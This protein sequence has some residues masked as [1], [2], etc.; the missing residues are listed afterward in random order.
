MKQLSFQTLQELEYPGYLNT[1]APERILQFGEGNFLRAFA[2][3]FI[4]L[5]NE[6]TDFNG[7]VVAVQPRSQNPDKADQI[8][9]QDGLYTIYERGYEHR[10]TVNRRKIISSLSRCLN[11]YRDGEELRKLA[12]SPDIR[13]VISNTTEA[14][15]RYDASASLEDE[16]PASFPAKITK[17]LYLRFLARQRML[18]EGQTDLLAGWVFL[19]CELID[20]NGPTLKSY[21]LQHAR[22]WNLGEDFIQWV[23]TENTFCSTM[24][25]R[26]VTGY[27]QGEARKLNHENGYTDEL[28]DTCEAFALWVIQGPEWLKDE[29]PFPRAHVP[30]IFTDDLLP[31]KL[32]KVRILNGSHTAMVPAAY[33][34][35]LNIVRDSMKNKLIRAFFD[36]A[37]QQEIIPTIPLPRYSCLSYMESVAERFVNPYIDHQLLSITLNT[38]SKWRARI[39]PTVLDY[40]KE[41]GRLPECLT[42]SFAFYLAFYR[43]R[44]KKDG[45]YYGRRGEGNFY[46]LKDDPEILEFFYAYRE[47]SRRSFVRAISQNSS[48]WGMDLSDLPDFLPKVNAYLT[49]IEEEGPDKAMEHALS[50]V[51]DW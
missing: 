36:A 32:Q 6:R 8:N 5:L 10:K 11:C 7:R 15:I 19:P 31:Y 14:G 21:I 51:Q 16:P 42:A 12:V 25:D 45:K 24:V 3:Y 43:I 34:C 37:A 9:A 41:K 47:V 40:V 48:F 30:V 23:E 38:T 18:A 2:D 22:D 35:G 44:E 28:L 50:S 26:I 1:S 13:F 49:I 33:L 17:L 20:H 29:L 27:P 39:L 4:D 46:E